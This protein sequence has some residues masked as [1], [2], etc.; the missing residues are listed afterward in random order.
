[1]Q[2]ECG[3]GL[4]YIKKK[5]KKILRFK[6][7][8]Q[9][10]PIVHF[11][12]AHVNL[13]FHKMWE[14]QRDLHA[15]SCEITCFFEFSQRC[16]YVSLNSYILF[17]DFREYSIS[18]MAQKFGLLSFDYEIESNTTFETNISSFSS[19][20]NLKKTTNCFYILWI[21]TNPQQ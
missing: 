17:W 15:L 1:M 2:I 3:R 18:A 7:I 16:G 21:P 12:Q 5:K 11:M 8:K 6:C 14:R 19:L 4:Q 13:S 9:R 20:S 10:S